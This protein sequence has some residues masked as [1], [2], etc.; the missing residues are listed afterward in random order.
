MSDFYG[1]KLILSVSFFKVLFGM[2]APNQ[3]AQVE[4]LYKRLGCTR[5]DP[6]GFQLVIRI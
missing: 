2:H 3:E 5:P 4:T 1:L 6:R